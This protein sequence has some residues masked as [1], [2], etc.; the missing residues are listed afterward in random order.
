ML[1]EYFTLYSWSIL[2]FDLV[3]RNYILEHLQQGHHNQS[4]HSNSQLWCIF[5]HH[6]QQSFKVLG[7]HNRKESLHN[8][9]HIFG[10]GEL[11]TKHCYALKHSE[12]TLM[13]TVL[14]NS[15]RRVFMKLK[16]CSATQK[17]LPHLKIRLPY[18]HHKSLPIPQPFAA[19]QHAGFL[20]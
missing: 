12:C 11:K 8:K 3:C 4:A 10:V 16:S 5:V 14:G 13:N 2:M 1:Q 7:L 20:R 17:N 15:M 19:L 9:P 18:C 6:L